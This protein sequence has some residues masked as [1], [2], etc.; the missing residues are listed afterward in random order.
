LLGL[1]LLHEEDT[2]LWKGWFAKAGLPNATVEQGPVYGD[3]LNLQAALRGL[4]I[5][6]IDSVLAAEDLAAGRLVRLFDIHAH[7][8]AYYLVAR[9]FSGLTEAG[10]A[11]SRWLLGQFAINAEAVFQAR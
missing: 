8:G 2:T 6:L 5:A 3:G 9:S 11:F 4:G 7:Y 10:T 1:P